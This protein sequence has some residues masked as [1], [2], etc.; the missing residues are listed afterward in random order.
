MYYVYD[1]QMSIWVDLPKS[2]NALL[3]FNLY[4]YCRGKEGQSNDLDLVGLKRGLR[5]FSAHCVVSTPF[6]SLVQSQINED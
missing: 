6:H 1:L 5:T 3:L 2:K 4:L